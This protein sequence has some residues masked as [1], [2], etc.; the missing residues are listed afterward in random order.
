VGVERH[1]A[2]DRAGSE[3][4]KPHDATAVPEEHRHQTLLDEEELFTR[5]A[6]ADQLLTALKGNRLAVVPYPLD[7]VLFERILDFQAA[8]RRCF[9]REV[10]IADV[11]RAIFDEQPI[12]HPFQRDPGRRTAVD[13]GGRG[14]HFGRRV[15]SLSAL[16]VRGVVSAWGV[17][18]R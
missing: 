9:Y 16:L 2:D 3:R 4:A 1:L 5:L 6:L 14:A 10:A 15:P 17:A 7:E 13:D 8:A 11:D 18:R 12:L